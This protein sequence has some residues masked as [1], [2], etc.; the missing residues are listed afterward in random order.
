VRNR[1]NGPLVTIASDRAQAGKDP[2]RPGGNLH[3]RFAS[4]T[5]VVEQLLIGALL[6][7]LGCRQSLVIAVVPLDPI[8]MICAF[9]PKPASSRVRRSGHGG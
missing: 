8:G 9:S 5:A 1:Q 6:K 2:I 4:R 7:N 3:Q